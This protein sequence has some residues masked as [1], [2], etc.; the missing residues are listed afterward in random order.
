MVESNKLQPAAMLETNIFQV[1]CRQLKS[2]VSS[3][4][5]SGRG[6]C[7]CGSRGEPSG[8]A[9]Q[10]K[11]K[12]GGEGKWTG[13]PIEPLTLPLWLIQDDLFDGRRPQKKGP[14][15]EILDPPLV[16]TKAPKCSWQISGSG[17]QSIPNFNTPLFTPL[18]ESTHHFR[19]SARPFPLCPLP[20]FKYFD[21][22]HPDC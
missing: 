19:K 17:S 13:G 22:Q 11:K 8:P 20:T 3:W 21:P 18:A 12:G 9:P 14:C 7:W 4:E 10:Q 15:N 16:W 2:T 1:C 6:V 5:G